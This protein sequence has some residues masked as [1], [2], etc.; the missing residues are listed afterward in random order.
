METIIFKDYFEFLDWC[1]EYDYTIINKNNTEIKSRDI[2]VIKGYCIPGKR[3]KNFNLIECHGEFYFK[4]PI[5]PIEENIDIKLLVFE[6]S[7]TDF[8]ISKKIY[9]VK[10]KDEVKNSVGKN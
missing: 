3:Y 6:K 1:Y 9:Y 8:E 5:A 4:K 2:F 7:K 10:Y